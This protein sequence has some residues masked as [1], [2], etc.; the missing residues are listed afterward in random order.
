MNGSF[1]VTNDLIKQGLGHITNNF[2]I[3]AVGE[4][5]EVDGKRV[6]KS[7]KLISIDF[8]SD[9]KGSVGNVIKKDEKKED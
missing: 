7:M 9:N 2:E 6:F 3:R 5:D 1:K 8:I 4:Y